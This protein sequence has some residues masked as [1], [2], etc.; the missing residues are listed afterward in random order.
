[1]GLLKG[2][3]VENKPRTDDDL[4]RNIT[5]ETAEIPPATLAATFR[6]KERCVSLSTGGGKPFSTAS[7]THLS[8]YV[9][10]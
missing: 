4:E 9:R 1:V 8:R 3:V 7:E 5:N 6:N 10:R 2:R